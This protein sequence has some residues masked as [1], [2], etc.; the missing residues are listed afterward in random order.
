MRRFQVPAT[1][2]LMLA[3][4]C[5]SGSG[6]STENPVEL[7]PP[8]GTVDNVILLLGSGLST[9]HIFCGRT[10]AAGPDGAMALDELDDFRSRNGGELKRFV[11]DSLDSRPRIFPPPEPADD[12]AAATQ[13]ATGRRVENGNVGVLPTGENLFTIREIA[14][15]FDKSTGLVTTA[16]IHDPTMAAFAADIVE[17]GT[18]PSRQFQV[19]SSLENEIESDVI[20]DM[21]ERA[22][23]TVMLGGGRA[24]WDRVGG[25]ELAQARFG[26]SGFDNALGMAR[27]RADLPGQPSQ[28]V[29]ALG[30][31]T[32]ELRVS[33][34]TEFND[35]LDN[36]TER[37]LTPRLVR[38]EFEEALEMGETPRVVPEDP[39][40]PDMVELALD[41]LE[42]DPQGFFLVI[43]S[44]LID[45]I[46][47]FA[48]FGVVFD[49]VPEDRWDA[50]AELMA[51]EVVRLDD[52]L[53]VV[54]DWLGARE[55]T[56]VI[57]AGDRECC[58]LE[59]FAKA[60]TDRTTPVDCFND[61]DG[62]G[63]EQ[64]DICRIRPEEPDFEEFSGFITEI[65]APGNGE[66]V[67]IF[68]KG[69]AEEL[70]RIQTR[71]VASRDL[72]D[73]MQIALTGFDG[74]IVPPADE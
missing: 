49:D 19:G 16:E 48:G 17:G 2:L 56:L 54:L 43:E 57:L 13:M 26:Y 14:T 24:D 28:F 67:P 10:L 25:F 38:A 41:V 46:L 64:G 37:S 9:Q 69:P 34:D 29:R 33:E 35:L 52:A 47:Q 63:Y 53:R 20:L 62:C 27:F 1:A 36:Y 3:A 60:D 59:V 72:F 31:F 15:L 7:P 11:T 71:L 61:P 5:N 66:P 50:S 74:I 40:F 23:P 70:D 12:A 58:G 22:Q 65:F 45:K 30:L 55:D 39:A 21:Y 73:I 51:H 6:T 42:E 68:A 32:G 4:A 8:G 18:D 44:G